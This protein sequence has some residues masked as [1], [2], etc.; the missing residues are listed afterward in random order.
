MN[1]FSTSCL[2]A[3]CIGVAGV[4]N[5]ALAQDEVAGLVQDHRL[6]FDGGMQTVI[7]TVSAWFDPGVGDLFSST[8]FNLT[9]DTD[10][11]VFFE[12][13]VDQHDSRR[14]IVIPPSTYINIV[15]GQ[16]HFP[17]I[18]AIGDESNPIPIA[19]FRFSTDDLRRRDLVVEVPLIFSFAVYPDAATGGAI[20]LDPG[21]FP[22]SIVWTIPIGL[23]CR[24]DFDE[25]G[26]LTIFD[27]LTF[28]NL[29][30]AGDPI[31]DFDGD[32]SLTLFDFLAFQNAFDAGCP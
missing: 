28:Q 10:E 27:F 11:P 24:A 25:D 31:A 22:E 16:F 8:I 7:I 9:V 23:P 30:D 12:P 20:A 18:G 3:S 26:Q 13:L 29:F 4:H 21:Q 32:G 6:E 5:H 14:L 1:R 17:L 2:L 19:E 15:L